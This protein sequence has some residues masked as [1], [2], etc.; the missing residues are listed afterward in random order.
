MKKLGITAVLVNTFET[1]EL[2]YK[3]TELFGEK[4][5]IDEDEWDYYYEL[6]KNSEFGF[7]TH[8]ISIEYLQSI[9]K[10]LK[11]AGGNYIEIKYHVDHQTY[12]IINYEVHK[13]TQD[14]LDEYELSYKESKSIAI[15]RKIEQL[16]KEISK[17]KLLQI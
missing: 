2:H 6:Q 5:D 4:Y 9:L 15:K 17:L 3:I 8:P 12:Y 1:E 7:N 16:E 13:T 11:S 10:D 14:E